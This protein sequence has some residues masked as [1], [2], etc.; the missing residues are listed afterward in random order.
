MTSA[1]G[2]KGKTSFTIDAFLARSAAGPSSLETYERQLRQAEAWLGKP[3]GS[4]TERD[5][6][7][8]KKKLRAMPSGPQYARLLRMFYKAA[9]RDDF[10]EL[11]VLKQRLKKLRPDDLLTVQEVQAMIDATG[12]LRDRAFLGVL[13]E[14]GVRVSELM[15]L[16]LADLRM[17][18]SPTNG[19]RK[20]YRLWFKKTKIAGEEHSGYVLEAAP[21]LEAWLKAHPDPRPEAPLFPTW[22]GTRLTRHGGYGIV[23]RAAR[24]AKIAKRIYP[25]IF[26]HSRATFLLASGMTDAQVKALL[27][28]VPGS[29]MLN[30]YA[31]LTSKDA[32]G[33]L[34]KVMGMEPEKVDLGK[35][36]F[37]EES[38]RPVVPMNAPPNALRMV[39]E[40]EIE[41][42]LAH[43]KVVR[44]L[45][46]LQAAK[47]T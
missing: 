8:L 20:V 23:A 28:W 14:T 35:L 31:H 41:E 9:K 22:G 34:L 29:M 17:T 18:D 44:L 42:L 19:G 40:K 32:Y 30:R 2:G 4:A 13:W 46:L 16:D 26:R 45:E 27:G 24:H 36:E 47:G 5:L 15:A 12:P 6:I 43:P 39:P 1:S 37:K 25:H 33:G 38:L 10:R 11:M 7:A 21:V 3:L